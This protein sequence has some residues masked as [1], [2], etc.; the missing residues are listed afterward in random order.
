MPTTS[1][2]LAHVFQVGTSKQLG[3]ALSFS[4]QELLNADLSV[5]YEEPAQEIVPPVKSQVAITDDNTEQRRT[6]EGIERFMN[7]IKAGEKLQELIGKKLQSHTV[8]VDP[9]TDPSVRTAVR[10][11]FG[12]DSSTI[13]YE[14]FKEAL[15]LR[16]QLIVQG[17]MESYG[18]AVD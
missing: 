7:V 10:R 14:M 13:T 11:M 16:S 15:R 2:R 8:T 9:R 17:R 5:A 1:D 4:D 3:S 12:I 6:E 18:I